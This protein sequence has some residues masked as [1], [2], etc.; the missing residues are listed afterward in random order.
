MP[1]RNAS[2]VCVCVCVCVCVHMCV[3]K[4]C[5]S[6]SEDVFGLFQTSLHEKEFI[7]IL[8]TCKTEPSCAGQK[9]RRTEIDLRFKSRGQQEMN[10]EG[11]LR[12]AGFSTSDRM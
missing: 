4:L 2:S 7:I 6:E 1:L 11:T 9:Q 12:P 8:N 3:S 5:V 10:S